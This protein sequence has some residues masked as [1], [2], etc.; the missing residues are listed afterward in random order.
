MGLSFF[1]PFGLYFEVVP[2][3]AHVLNRLALSVEDARTRVADRDG[4]FKSICCYRGW[5]SIH[6]YFWII[7]SV[8]L[9]TAVTESPTFKF[10]SSALRRVMTLSIS[11]SPT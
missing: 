9:M 3:P 4:K 2:N 1:L 7:T 8:D 11:F 6:C 5:N 10:N